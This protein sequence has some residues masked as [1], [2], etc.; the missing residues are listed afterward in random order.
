MNVE[1]CL[2]TRDADV[3]SPGVLVDQ[4]AL[5]QRGQVAPVL[6]LGRLGRELVPVHT[7]QFLHETGQ[8][9]LAVDPEV[10]GRTETVETAVPL[11]ECTEYLIDSS[12]M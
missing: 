12:S 5:I 4:E 1:E 9:V 3:A 8:L 11:H 2:A 6:S 10:S 7:L